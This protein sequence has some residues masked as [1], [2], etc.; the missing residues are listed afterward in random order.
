MMSE[1]SVVSLPVAP[2]RRIAGLVF[3]CC[4]VVKKRVLPPCDSPDEPSR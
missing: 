1:L 3:T 2:L 4:A